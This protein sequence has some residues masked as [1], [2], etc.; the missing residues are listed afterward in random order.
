M[1]WQLKQNNLFGGVIFVYDGELYEPS[2]MFPGTHST[3][4]D[5][6]KEW[7]SK[8]KL[9]QYQRRKAYSF[10]QQ[11]PE[12]PQLEYICHR[13]KK[14]DEP[15]KQLS[16]RLPESI[17]DKLKA[18]DISIVGYIYNAVVEKLERENE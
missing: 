2:D 7:A 16:I 10:L 3:V 9:N 11:W 14:F 18:K 8:T 13:P 12:G 6:V 4:A 17:H 5:I 1:N 15:T